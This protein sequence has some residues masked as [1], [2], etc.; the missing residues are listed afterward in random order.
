WRHGSRGRGGGGG[1]MAEG[2]VR[3]KTGSAL[4]VVDDRDFEERVRFLAAEQAHGEEGEEGD[5]VDD[6]LGHAPAG[7][8]DDERFSELES[9]DAR[10][11]DSVVETGE[12]DELC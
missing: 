4:R 6:A 10:G 12:H 7:V 8:S 2:G 11:V 1:V 9:E 3:E 5:V